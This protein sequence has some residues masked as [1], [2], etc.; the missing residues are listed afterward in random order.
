MSPSRRDALRASGAALSLAVAGC[1]SGTGDS[2]E[3]STTGVTTHTQTPESS[4]ERTTE[5]PIQTTTETPPEV[6][7][8]SPSEV[9]RSVP[10]S[11]ELQHA[12]PT[13]PEIAFV[14]GER[15]ED[16]FAHKP[17]L[18]AVWNDTESSLSVELALT[19][20]ETTLL[21]QSVELDSGQQVPIE[22]REP[23]RYELVVR[24]DGREKT[25]TVPRSQLDCNDS[26]T[27]VLVRPEEVVVGSVTTDMGC[28]TTTE[29]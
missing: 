19:S 15:P 7:E 27:D 3:S 29:A 16:T 18:F 2:G 6:R 10:Q 24:A 11:R 4:S 17:H 23:R 21:E 26:A 25:V 5:A 22:L 12:E 1:L 20:N 14:V 8:V 28:G 13:D 9:E